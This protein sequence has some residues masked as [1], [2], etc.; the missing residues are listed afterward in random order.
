MDDPQYLSN[1]KCI[2]FK[3]PNNLKLCTWTELEYEVELKK[4]II[5]KVI[6]KGLG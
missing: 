6:F 5:R 3:M 4:K 2:E 1:L